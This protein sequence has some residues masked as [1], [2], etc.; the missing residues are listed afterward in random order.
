MDTVSSITFYTSII[1][2]FVV[3]MSE[4]FVISARKLKLDPSALITLSLYFIVMLIRFLRCF[5]SNNTDTPLQIGISLSCHTLIS[6]S[7]YYF[8]FEMQTVRYQ[9]ECA[10][11]EE[12]V[13]KRRIN[14][15]RKLIVMFVSA[16]YGIS[17][18]VIRVLFS[19]NGKFN[20][21]EKVIYIIAFTVK[22]LLDT[23]AI[24]IFVYNLSYFLQRKRQALQKEAL[25]FT[26]FNRFI[27]GSIYFLLFMRI[28]GSLYTFIIGIITLT[29]LYDTDAQK[30]SYEIL[31][32]LVFPIRDFVE[33]LFFSYLF[34][35]QSKKRID[36]AKVNQV[37]RESTA[38][39]SPLRP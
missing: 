23:Y 7:M 21:V 15:R 30:L 10:N 11:N 31:D 29:P 20:S 8:V 6:M 35:Y 36:L 18:T 25:V 34:F 2:F 39:R 33:V 4:G 38:H 14:N 28:A 17:Y 37:W 13:E 19:L 27:L 24:T 3:S 12:Y 9:M 16:V 5:I 22:L 1:I 26:P 32:D